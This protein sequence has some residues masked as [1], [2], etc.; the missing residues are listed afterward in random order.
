MAAGGE[1]DVD[2][3]EPHG[4][5]L[6]LNGESSSGLPET[7]K[8]DESQEVTPTASSA[9]VKVISPQTPSG[10]VLLPMGVPVA[11][12]Q[13]IPQVRYISVSLLFDQN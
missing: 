9:Q 6:S 5:A 7:R 4:R 11:M 13:P 12:Q 1:G 2:S 3:S 10:S 8:G